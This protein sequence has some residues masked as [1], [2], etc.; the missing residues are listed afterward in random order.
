VS[1]FRGSFQPAN[2]PAAPN[3]AVIMCGFGGVVNFQ[4][5]ASGVARIE[6]N[7]NAFNDTLNGGGQY[8]IR[9]GAGAAPAQ[10]AGLAGNLG[11][12]QLKQATFGTANATYPFCVA[13]VLSGLPIGVPLWADLAISDNN[14]TGNFRLQAIDASVVEL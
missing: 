13:V 6:F 2:P 9:V 8:Q 4:L 10:G 14:G 3:A 12:S 7:G 11:S 1:P 5:Q